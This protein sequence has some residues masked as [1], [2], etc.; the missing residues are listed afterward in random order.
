MV[1]PSIDEQVKQ[2][3]WNLQNHKPTDEAIEKIED[4][5]NY[6]QMFAEKIAMVCPNSRE[7]SLAQTNVEQATMWAVASIA[8]TETEDKK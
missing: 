4:L 3:H 8:R 5:R 2:A 1:E 6:A 7:K